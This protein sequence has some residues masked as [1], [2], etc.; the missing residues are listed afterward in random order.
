MFQK[1]YH[2]SRRISSNA[3]RL[4]GLYKN[5]YQND[6][7]LIEFLSKLF[8]NFEIYRQYIENLLYFRKMFKNTKATATPALTYINLDVKNLDKKYLFFHFEKR[9]E[10]FNFI[11]ERPLPGPPYQLYC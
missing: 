5:E 10:K 6:S 3:Y 2:Y 4:V 1:T 9:Y 11:Y 7:K 8:S